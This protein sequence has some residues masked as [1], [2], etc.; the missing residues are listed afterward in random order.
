MGPTLLFYIHLPL[1]A[2]QYYSIKGFYEFFISHGINGDTRPIAMFQFLTFWGQLII[3]L[4][5]FISTLV[6]LVAIYYG[7]DKESKVNDNALYVVLLNARDHLFRGVLFPVTVTVTVMFWGIYYVDKELIYP[8]EVAAIFPS[9]LNHIQHTMPGIFAVVELLLINHQ[10]HRALPTSAEA[11]S[12]RPDTS[13]LYRDVTNMLSFLFFYIIVILV[14]R[15]SFGYWAYPI[16]EI[17][18]LHSKI[19]FILSSSCFFLTLYIF[20]RLLAKG[21]WGGVS[22]FMAPPPGLFKVQ[23]QQAKAMSQQTKVKAQ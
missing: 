3:A 21:R 14:A 12:K 10:F 5:L 20:E 9:I 6:N 2:V 16:L 23:Q 18:P 8:D 17:I 4:F 11:K 13:G 19:I 15:Y 7:D 22:E 1:L